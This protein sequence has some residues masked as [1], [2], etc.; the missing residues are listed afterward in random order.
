M[1]LV[2]LRHST[3]Y[4]D[5]SQSSSYLFNFVNLGLKQLIVTTFLFYSGYGIYES[6]KNKD[7]Y[8]NI[9]LPKRIKKLYIYF[10]VS[11]ISYL[12]M[13]SFLDIKYDIKT[14][15]SSLFT[16][17]SIGN[18]NWYIFAIISMYFFTY[19]CFKVLKKDLH[20]I[21]GVTF[22]INLYTIILSLFKYSYWYDTVI[23]FALGL[24][25]SYY[26]ERIFS[27]FTRNNFIYSVSLFIV[28][29]YFYTFYKL[30]P[31]NVVFHELWALSFVILIMLI[32]LKFKI[33]SKILLF[34][35]KYTF[36][37]YILQRMS[38]IILDKFYITDFRNYLFI[39]FSFIITIILAMIYKKVFDKF[40]FIGFSKKNE[41]N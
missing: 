27:F 10:L 38:M 16:W 33:Y 23:C 37:I 6:I 28:T 7:N 19:I 25:V 17:E 14:V 3:D 9:T 35:G 2:F 18:S 29:L 30:H 39:T 13:N 32:S 21:A 40:N 5:F 20:A 12:V 11:V 26:K 1:I 41:I 22:L 36:W 15:I 24:F 34:L 8:V 4:C 31:F